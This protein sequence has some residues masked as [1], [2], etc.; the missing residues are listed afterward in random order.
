MSSSLHHPSHS[1]WYQKSVCGPATH[2]SKV[3]KHARLVER[4]FALFQM[5][6]TGVGKSGGLLSKGLLSHL[7]TDNQWG[8]R[9]YRQKEGATCRNS[10]ISSDSRLPSSR[11][12]VFPFLCSQF[13][14]LWQL[15]SWVQSGHHV[16][17][18][19]WCF[20]I[21]KTAHWIWLRILSTALEKE[22]KVLGWGEQGPYCP[23]PFHYDKIISD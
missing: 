14:E 9:F 12:H 2:C 10:T 8:K 19:T 15:M 13:S 17:N 21:S 11:V 6:A 16:A 3:N 4:K 20:S 22:L 23:V 7:T 1:Y 18:F 5:P